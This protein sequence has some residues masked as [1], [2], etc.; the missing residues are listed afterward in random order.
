MLGWRPGDWRCGSGLSLS[1]SSTW[2]DLQLPLTPLLG[3]SM[4]YSD[5]EATTPVYIIK[6]KNES[7]K[8]LE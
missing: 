1:P 7:K 2:K 8:K 3:D 6:N 5:F 4:L